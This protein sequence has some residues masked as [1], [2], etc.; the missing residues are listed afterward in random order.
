MTVAS[1]DGQTVTART[2]IK[3][4]IRMLGQSR[5]PKDA[6]ISDGL[7]ALNDM[8]DTWRN[9]KLMA[10]AFQEETL[11]LTGAATY[12]IGPSGTIATNRPVRIESAVGVRA[13]GSTYPIRVV[14]EE[15]Y[16]GVTNRSQTADQ[17]DVL[18]YKA[19]LPDGTI[20]VTPLSSSGTIRLVTR[21]ALLAFATADATTYLPPGWR[22]ALATNLAL[23]LAPEYETEA[24]PKVEKRAIASMA[25]IKRVNSRPEVV[26]TDLVEL[27]G[28]GPRSNI[29]TDGQ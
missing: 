11:T 1:F 21:V 15:L 23:I 17:P 19:T 14:N 18:N 20:Y 12:S 16:A 26:A 9:D 8:L 10:Y 2:I 4:A 27:V 22:E 29:L 6:E 5:T 25:S 7:E 24:P 3:R 13:D 28:C